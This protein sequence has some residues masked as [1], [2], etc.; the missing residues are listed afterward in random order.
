MQTKKPSFQSVASTTTGLLKSLRLRFVFHCIAYHWA[1][2]S[3][4]CAA[5]CRRVLDF[6]TY[7]DQAQLPLP[8][9]V[10]YAK[11]NSSL[12]I[13]INNIKNFTAS[14]QIFTVGFLLHLLYINKA[15]R[16]KQQTIGIDVTS[17]KGLSHLLLTCQ[18]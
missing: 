11:L 8:V 1:S 16:E 6:V 7:K 13:D 4:I 10:V 17:S 3:Y 9:C 15:L 2:Y 12:T 5:D 14:R 18:L